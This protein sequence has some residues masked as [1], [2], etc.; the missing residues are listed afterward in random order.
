MAVGRGGRIDAHGLHWK[1]RLRKRI[2][3]Q[4]TSSNGLEVGKCDG[5][6]RGPRTECVLQTVPCFAQKFLK[7]TAL[8]VNCI[9]SLQCLRQLSLP[10]SM[11]RHNEYQ[12]SGWVIIQMAMGECSAY[13]GLQAD[14]KVKFLAWPTSWRELDHIHS[15]DPSE[16]LCNKRQHY[17]HWSGYY[18]LGHH[19]IPPTLIVSAVSGSFWFGIPSHALS[20][21]FQ[22]SVRCPHSLS[23]STPP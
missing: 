10:T 15:N 21:L 22:N 7:H 18:Y 16:L 1:V 17:K 23:D 12:P 5:D 9:P 2:S 14:S 20:K 6:T 4:F 3:W 13:S 19:Q 8:G 11:E